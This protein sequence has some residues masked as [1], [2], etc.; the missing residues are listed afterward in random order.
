MPQCVQRLQQET[1]SH[2]NPK[3]FW[4]ATGSDEEKLAQI[5][6]DYLFIMLCNSYKDTKTTQSA[7]TKTSFL[8]FYSQLNKQHCIKTIGMICNSKVL[9]LGITLKVRV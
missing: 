7:G 5:M 3:Y 4:L 6:F 8:D 9:K 1:N 2:K